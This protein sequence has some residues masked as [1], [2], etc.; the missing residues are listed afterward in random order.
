MKI[1][2]ITGVNGENERTAKGLQLTRVV[3]PSFSV[4]LGNRDVGR[5]FMHSYCV[6]THRFQNYL[7]MGQGPCREKRRRE[8]WQRK[9]N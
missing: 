3:P 8:T 2:R 6:S 1:Q 7:E 5:F 4:P 9:K